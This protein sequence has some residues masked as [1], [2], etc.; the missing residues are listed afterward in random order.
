MSKNRPL[1]GDDGMALPVLPPDR[2]P[3]LWT[4]MVRIMFFTPGF[5][6]LLLIKAGEPAAF[7][8]TIEMLLLACA[9]SVVGGLFIG[10][11]ASGAGSDVA[12]RTSLWC[13]GLVLEFLSVVPFLCALPALFHQLANSTLLHAH[14]PNAA[15][16]ALGASELIPM[17]AI[18]PFLIYQL[19]GFGVMSYVI[20]RSANLLL[21]STIVAAIVAGYVANRMANFG[22]EKAVS[23]LLVILMLYV[24]FFGIRKLKAMQA[25]YD[26]RVPVKA[27]KEGKKTKDDEQDE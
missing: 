21:N 9:A 2:D 12:S 18:V 16:V 6:A 1:L 19:S 13:A 5:L 10:S 26:A 3:R 4:R 24:V 8:V 7:G 11:Q 22:V 14:A 25:D 27:A 20:S 15:D 23:G 17:A